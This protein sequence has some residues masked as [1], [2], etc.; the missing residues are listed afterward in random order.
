MK[1]RQEGRGNW[2]ELC[3]TYQQF[4]IITTGGLYSEEGDISKLGTFLGVVAPSHTACD[5]NFILL[6]LT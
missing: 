2:F 3:F 5:N 6:S 4:E 1:K